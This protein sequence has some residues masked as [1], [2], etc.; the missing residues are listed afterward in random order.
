MTDNRRRIL[1]ICSNLPAA[2]AW[3]CFAP[4]VSGTARAIAITAT[5]SIRVLTMNGMANNRLRPG[6]TN[7]SFDTPNTCCQSPATCKSTSRSQLCRKTCFGLSPPERTADNS[8]A[9]HRWE[10]R[11]WR[12]EVRETDD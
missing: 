1:R 4:N 12:G 2:S 10:D 8:P 6:F 7:I 5:S 11:Q 9:I 3:R